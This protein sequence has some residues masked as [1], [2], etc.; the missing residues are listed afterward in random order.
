[1][2]RKRIALVLA[3]FLFFFFLA[4]I[5]SSYGAGQQEADQILPVE[6]QEEN[7]PEKIVGAPQDAKQKTGIWVFVAWMWI[8]VLVLIFFLRLK[9]KEVDRLYRLRFFSA[10]KN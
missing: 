4:W 1:V 9:I 8:S 5:G 7:V 3:T 6:Q 2:K 10:K